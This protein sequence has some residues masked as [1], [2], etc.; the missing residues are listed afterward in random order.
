MDRVAGKVALITGGSRGMGASHARRLIAEGASVVIGD[1][2]DAE[3][4]ALAAE[5]GDKAL[6][7]H[8]D[9]TSRHDWAAAVLATKERFG[10]IDVLVN[11]AGIATGARI[12]E[13]ELRLWQKTIDIN[14]TGAF[15]GIQA[16]VVGMVEQGSGSI[17]NISSVEGLRGSA[18]LHAYVAT[19]FALRGLTKSVAV[20]I[21][22]TGVRVNSIHPGFITTPMTAGISAD[23]L[24]IPLGRAADPS[25]VSSLVLFLASD[26]SRYSTGSEFVI[27]GGLTAGIPHA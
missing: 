25:E 17:I 19:K 1:V 9:V 23:Q 3:G 21:G 27:D 20:E 13:F 4:T 24:Q 15:L 10:T 26:E 5:L 6:F 2:L 14:L 11:N 22:S 12:A 16:V 7:V 8:L 18:N